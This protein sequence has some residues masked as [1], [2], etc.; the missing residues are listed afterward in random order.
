MEQGTWYVACHA[1]TRGADGKKVFGEWSEVKEVQVT[2]VT[3]ETPQIEKI[4]VKGTTVTV[5]YTVSENAQGY[6]VVLGSRQGKVND[7]KRPLA[8]GKYVKKMNGNKLTMTFTNVK[9][10][11]YY[12]GLHAWNRSSEDNSK[13]FSKWSDVE[14]FKLK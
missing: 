8:Y 14:R 2:S 10:G 1:W 6:D 12:A 3:P 4:T 9:P 5:T 7:E 13:V 11:T